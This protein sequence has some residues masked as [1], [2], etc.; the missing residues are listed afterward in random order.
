[1]GEECSAWCYGTC[2]VHVC[3]SSL[4]D[5]GRQL[6]QV[7]LLLLFCFKLKMNTQYTEKSTSVS[8]NSVYN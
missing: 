4:K 8:I 5:I 7:F 6:K 3:F 2:S 1:M